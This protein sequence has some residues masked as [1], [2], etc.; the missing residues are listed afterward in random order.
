[1]IRGA[2]IDLEMGVSPTSRTS[3]HLNGVGKVL[4]IKKMKDNAG[5][6]IKKTCKQAGFL[7]GSARKFA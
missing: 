6:T 4:Q 2:L 7:P 5:D 3:Q 1:L